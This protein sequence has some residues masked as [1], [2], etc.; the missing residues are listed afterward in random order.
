MLIDIVF[1]IIVVLACIKGFQKGLIIALFSVLAFVIGLAAALKLSAVLA[2]YLDGSLNVSAKWLPVISFALVFFGVVLLVRMGARL[3]EKTFQMALLGWVNR[4]GGIVLYAALY[5]IILSIFLF[6]A[7][8]I[9]LI[10]P[11]V[12]KASATYS[13]VQPWGPA[14]IDNFGKVI[15]IFKDTFADLEKFFGNVGG[16]LPQ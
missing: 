12:I 4:I 2:N 14:V 1:A 3:V 6:Y 7:E 15:P 8:K 5:I 9:K 10:D 16:Q 13:F 11:E